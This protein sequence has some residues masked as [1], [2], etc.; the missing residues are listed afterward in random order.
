MRLAEDGFLLFPVRLQRT[1]SI[2][3]R[4]MGTEYSSLMPFL[5]IKY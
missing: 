5:K 2:V 3:S 1:G 4:G